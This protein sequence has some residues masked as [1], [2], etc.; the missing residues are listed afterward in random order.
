MT[1]T[2]SQG[3]ETK[4]AQPITLLKNPIHKTPSLLY[5]FVKGQMWQGRYTSPCVRC[6][7]E[8]S[9]EIADREND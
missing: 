8:S 4:L 3:E 1:Y 5:I 2:N 9:S 6:A 7:P